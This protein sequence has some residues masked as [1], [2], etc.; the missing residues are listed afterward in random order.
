MENKN[1]L[2]RLKKKVYFS[3]G[4]YNSKINYQKSKKSRR[5]S[6]F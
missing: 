2:P 1:N 5:I 3:Q 6:I 4:I